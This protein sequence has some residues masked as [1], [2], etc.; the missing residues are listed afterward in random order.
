MA[1]L[2]NG[3]VDRRYLSDQDNDNYQRG[4]G[5][6]E[7]ATAKAR[8]QGRRGSISYQAN[9]PPNTTISKEQGKARGRAPETPGFGDFTRYGAESQRQRMTDISQE[10]E[11]AESFKPT[12][13]SV[14]DIYQ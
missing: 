5:F 10:K 13:M 12:M 3:P 4:G 2:R 11:R 14:E 8:A 9:R 6:G 7:R 1:G